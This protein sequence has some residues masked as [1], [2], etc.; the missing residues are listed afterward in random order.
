MTKFVDSRIK[1]NIEKDSSEIVSTLFPYIDK[2]ISDKIKEHIQFL[3][4][5]L[6]KTF[7]QE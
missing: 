1:E 7:K 3:G 2:V 5:T 6:I 4:E